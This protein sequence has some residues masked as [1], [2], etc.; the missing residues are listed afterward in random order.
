[1][2]RYLT[3]TLSYNTSGGDGLPPGKEWRKEEWKARVKKW[4]EFGKYVAEGVYHGMTGEY[5]D[6]DYVYFILHDQV[7][8]K[9]KNGWCVSEK[10]KII[11]R[12]ERGFFTGNEEDFPNN[13]DFTPWE[14]IG[15]QAF[16]SKKEAWQM[17]EKLAKMELGFK[18][19]FE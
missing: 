4:A 2:S 3:Q 8:T 5:I 6:L 15:I 16:Y 10:H 11:D 12:S 9:S 7:E 13:A 17:C 19:G 14:D 1:M 18:D